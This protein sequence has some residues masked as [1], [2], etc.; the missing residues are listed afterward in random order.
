MKKALSLAFA[1]MMLISMICAIPVIA[2]EADGT[3]ANPYYVANPMAA[4]Q[5]ITI[6]ANTTVYYQYNAMVFNGWE[7]G[8]YGLTSITVDGFGEYSDCEIARLLGIS[9]ATVSYRKKDALR[10]L[11]VMMEAMDH[12]N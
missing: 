11:R 6:P 7:I 8:G 1:L 9:N 12:E 4:P 10:R 3:A 2:D 5:L